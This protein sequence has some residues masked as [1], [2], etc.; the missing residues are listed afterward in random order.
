MCRKSKIKEPK[1]LRGVWLAKDHECKRKKWRYKQKWFKSLKPLNRNLSHLE[2]IFEYV[3]IVTLH[4]SDGQSSR[5]STMKHLE[6]DANIKAISKVLWASWKIIYKNPHLFYWEIDSLRSEFTIPAYRENAQNAS[7][8]KMHRCPRPFNLRKIRAPHSN[9]FWG[10]RFHN[11]ALGCQE[12][13]SLL[14]TA[15]CHQSI[16]IK[17]KI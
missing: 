12:N 17:R 7:N 11:S 3:F 16:I 15:N 2:F 1:I 9:R 6:T 14:K 10:T 5:I 4:V 13:D 8:I